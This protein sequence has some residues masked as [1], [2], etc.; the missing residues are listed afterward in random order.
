MT[1]M[2]DAA[3]E[4]SAAAAEQYFQGQEMLMEG[5]GEGD[6]DFFEPYETP[7]QRPTK[8][9]RVDMSDRGH[10]AWADMPAEM[11]MRASVEAAKRLV[12]EG[13]NSGGE[14]AGGS[15]SGLVGA[16]EGPPATS[17]TR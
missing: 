8:Q 7:P 14:A 2:G 10:P 12:M 11:M 16:G 3:A 15:G 6:G 13:A 1:M 17:L 4:G 9:Q 5:E